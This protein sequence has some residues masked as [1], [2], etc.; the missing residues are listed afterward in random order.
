[1]ASENKVVLIGDSGVGKSSI[2]SSLFGKFNEVEPTTI[3][4]SYQKYQ[5]PD[6]GIILGIWDTAGQERFR[7]MVKLYY[8]KVKVILMIF[9]MTSEKSFKGIP[10]WYK[11]MKNAMLENNDNPLVYLIGTKFDL[12]KDNCNNNIDR[13][14]EYALR[15]EVSF[16]YTS[17]K[18]GLNISELFSTI[19]KDMKKY[20]FHCVKEDNSIIINRF[21]SDS[22]R[23]CF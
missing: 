18:L 1:M 4:C 7:S 9:D 13:F 6:T 23:C 19:C 15:N 5:D 2:V 10:A 20:N 14:N 11:D 3:G 8:R 21:S 17:A 22:G 16:F 12:L